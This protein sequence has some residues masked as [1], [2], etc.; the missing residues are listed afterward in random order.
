MVF[1]V[2]CFPYVR[3]SLKVADID[4]DTYASLFESVYYAG[5]FSIQDEIV[6]HYNN[7]PFNGQLLTNS[8]L[9]IGNFENGLPQGMFKLYDVQTDEMV[10][11]GIYFKGNKQGLWKKFFDNNLIEEQQFVNGQAEGINYQ[12]GPKSGKLYR[13]GFYKAN[14][15][16]GDWV[17]YY[18]NG[19]VFCDGRFEA[20]VKK[21]FGE[22]LNKTVTFKK[23]YITMTVCLF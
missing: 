8:N 5:Q 13:K 6:F 14:L 4:K 21:E 16:H 12:Y 17:Y 2:F 11:Q 23:R 9:L 7:K 20:G 10:C 1:C 22:D 18:K 19:K 3:N 15:K